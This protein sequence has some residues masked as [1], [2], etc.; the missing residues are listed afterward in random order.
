MERTYKEGTR[1]QEKE[2]TKSVTF[3]LNPLPSKEWNRRGIL[4]RWMN[5][6]GSSVVT[7]VLG[8]DPFRSLAITQL[9]RLC[10]IVFLLFTLT[11]SSSHAQQQKE[12]NEKRV[13]ENKKTDSGDKWF[14]MDKFL[15]FAASAGITGLSYHYYHCQYN[16]PE[17]NSIYF[18]ISFAGAAGI[19]KEVYDHRYKKTGWSW[20][21]IVVDAAGI[22]VGYL[23]FIK[24]SKK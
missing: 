6:D 24:L 18:S 10:L 21:D 1:A 15:H 3:T 19:G 9:F 8:S 12:T 22:A 20:K 5:Q 7:S 16:N 14:A 17:K 13:E 2:M 4:P 23:L 11:L